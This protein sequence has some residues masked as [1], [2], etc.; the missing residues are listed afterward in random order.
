MISTM[1]VLFAWFLWTIVCAGFVPRM[2]FW[3]LGSAL[4]FMCMVWLGHSINPILGSFFGI[5]MVFWFIAP[6][7]RLCCMGPLYRWAQGHSP[8]LSKTESE[9]LTCGDVWLE[10]KLFQA[11]LTLD[12]LKA[13]KSGRLTAE[14]RYFLVN[15]TTQLCGLL[16][17]W[18]R[19]RKQITEPALSRSIWTFMRKQGFFGLVIPK[20]YGGLGFSAQAHAAILKKL[21]SSSV[22]GVVTVM[23]PN[24]LGPAELLLH[25]GTHE[26]KQKYLPDLAIG[27]HIPCFALTED[28]VGSDATALSSVGRICKKKINGR[29]CLGFSLSFSKRYIT[30]APV[31]TLIGVAFVAQDPDHLLGNRED[32]GITLALLPRKTKGLTIG[33]RHMPMG[34]NFLNGPIVGKDCFVPLE[35]VIGGQEYIGR[36]WSMLIQCLATGRGISLPAVSAGYAA[37]AMLTTSAYVGCREQFGVAIQKFEGVSCVLARMGG[38]SYMIEA[39]SQFSLIPIDQGLK[40]SVVSSIAKYH[41]TEMSRQVI[42]DAMDLHGGKAIMWG[43]NNY[44]AAPYLGVPISITVEGANIMMRSLMIFG[45]GSLRCHR[46]LLAEMDALKRRDKRQG[47]RDFD[48]LVR[49]HLADSGRYKVRAWLHGLTGGVF[50]ARGPEELGPYW[51]RMQ[52][53]MVAFAFI[54]DVCLLLFGGRIKRMEQLS[55]RLGDV[56]SHLWIGFALI[57]Y[58]QQDGARTQDLV[59]VHWGLANR[60]A[61]A[62]A[63]LKVLL[64]NLPVFGFL[65]HALTWIIFPWGG[66]NKVVDDQLDRRLAAW[67]GTKTHWRAK[68]VRNLYVPNDLKHPVYCLEEALAQKI[69]LEPF[70]VRLNHW[71]REGKIAKHQRLRAKVI[72]ARSLGLIDRHIERRLLTYVTLVEQAICVDS[73]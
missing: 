1:V 27:K 6:L 48:C 38:F 26:Q 66:G 33:A 32:L 63:A 62:Q 55:A 72:Q 15:E 54:S 21:A 24:S 22:A 71:V 23:V 51:Q 67:L 61:L 29:M 53:L 4:L 17:D 35:E 18:R 57:H 42:Q 58:W 43:P 9:A 41:C 52:R 14:E 70:L 44:L 16:N 39:L 40:P 34:L 46:Y 49:N 5:M 8:T 36:G 69:K 11:H 68:M 60:L 73:I 10:Q 59:I 31:A 2:W 45:Q 19:Q 25:Y 65:R 7:R 50:L 3:A 20:R 30:L 47:L 12:D 64:A 37:L 28:E 56:F 13:L